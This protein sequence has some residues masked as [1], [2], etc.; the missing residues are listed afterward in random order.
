MFIYKY[1]LNRNK[2]S[3]YEKITANNKNNKQ[4]TILTCM[5]AYDINKLIQSVTSIYNFFKNILM[6]EKM[7]LHAY[8]I[9]IRS[10]TRKYIEP[11]NCKKS[12]KSPIQHVVCVGKQ[13]NLPQKNGV[14][15][16]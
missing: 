4:K 13:I 1:I 11:K 5:W 2:K 16:N 3:T 15:K 14:Y 9:K 7:E 6:M 12:N 10:K 8:I